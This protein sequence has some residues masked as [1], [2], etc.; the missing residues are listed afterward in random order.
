MLEAER[1]GERLRVRGEREPLIETEA[2]E[3]GEWEES[4]RGENRDQRR[5]EAAGQPCGP[6]GRFLPG[7]I[8]RPLL[9]WMGL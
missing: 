4:R 2:G 7:D 8:N 3:K 1:G 5:Q 6:Y 9:G